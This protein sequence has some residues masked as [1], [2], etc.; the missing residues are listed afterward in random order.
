MKKKNSSCSIVISSI[1]K[2]NECNKYKSNAFDENTFFQLDL[3][4]KKIYKDFEYFGEII[5]QTDTHITI[6][7][8]S[9]NRYMNG[10]ILTIQI[11]Y[12]K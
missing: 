5:K 12:F 11:A 3:I 9:G 6:R 4:N 2:N 8:N 7:V 1:S 10:Q